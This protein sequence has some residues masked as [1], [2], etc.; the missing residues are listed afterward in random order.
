MIRSVHG[1]GRLWTNLCGVEYESSD[2]SMA[3]TLDLVH[4][5]GRGYTGDDNVTLLLEIEDE[6]ET[7]WRVSSENN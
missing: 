1:R 7:K 6:R 2:I 4:G 3:L 5:F